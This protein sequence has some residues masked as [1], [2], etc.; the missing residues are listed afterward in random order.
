MAFFSS[1]PNSSQISQLNKQINQN[2]AV[3]N[4]KYTDIGRIVKLKYIDN[5]ND[6]DVKRLAGEIDSML[7]QLQAMNK[8][9]NQLKGIRECANC[10]AQIGINVAFCP[11]CGT[12]QPVAAQPAPA[13]PAAGGGWGAPAPSPAPVQP[14]QYVQPQP[15]PMP[16][17]VTPAAPVPQP[18]APVPQPEP[19]IPQLQPVTI[20]DPIPEEKPDPEPIVIPEPVE[21]E[22]A[23]ETA[24]PELKPIPEYI[25]PEPM[26]I[27]E[28]SPIP[29]SVIPEP[30]PIPE[31]APA[32]V[33]VPNTAA[34]PQFI[35]CTACGNK[36][37]V[38]TRFCSECGA[39]IE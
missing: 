32:P 1:N 31:P 29:E 5:I 22:K 21:K 16:Q 35:F 28:P 11:N 3:I 12:K 4:Q 26:T 6:A 2:L 34:A 27:P 18:V 20:P 39:P 15:V 36:E 7:A 10:R 19:V 24:V 30:M 14:Q 25:P 9:I 8:Q 37:T 38:G 23:E 33:P 13:A 17:P